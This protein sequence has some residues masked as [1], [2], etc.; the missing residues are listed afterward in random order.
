VTSELLTQTR[1]GTLYFCAVKYTNP[2]PASC[3]QCLYVGTTP[4][5]IENGWVQVPVYAK[6][7]MITY[8]GMCLQDSWG[9]MY[10][11]TCDKSPATCPGNREFWLGDT[12]CTPGGYQ[13]TNFGYS[14]SCSDTYL[15]AQYAGSTQV[16]CS[17]VPWQLY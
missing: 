7:A 2:G 4:I 9:G 11:P 15:L 1:G 16:N 14:W 10:T 17:G 12:A 13:G 5:W 3:Q 6:C 8:E